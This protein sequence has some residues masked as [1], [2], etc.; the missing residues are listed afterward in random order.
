MHAGL[1]SPKSRAEKLTLK[2]MEGVLRPL[3]D[4]RLRNEQ[5]CPQ[6]VRGGPERFHPEVN[7]P[8]P[9]GFDGGCSAGVHSVSTTVG[10]S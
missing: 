5:D 6:R 10:G 2:D 3:F 4:R 7:R 8:A 9:D 1:V